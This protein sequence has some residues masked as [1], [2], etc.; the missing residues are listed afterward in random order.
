MIQLLLAFTC[1]L[2]FKLDHIDVKLDFLN[3]FVN[4]EMN[5]SKSLG[6]EGRE[7]HVCF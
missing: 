2:D 1:R 6:F 4:E 3:N 7:N 5:V